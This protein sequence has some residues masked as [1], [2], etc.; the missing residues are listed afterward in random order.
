MPVEIRGRPAGALRHPSQYRGFRAS[1][2]FLANF[3]LTLCFYRRAQVVLGDG[4]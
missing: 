4:I 2:V 3:E 1:G